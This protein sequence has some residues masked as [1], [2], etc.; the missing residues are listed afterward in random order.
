MPAKNSPSATPSKARTKIVTDD[1]GVSYTL[2]YGGGS[3]KHFDIDP[4]I[5][6]TR[7][8]WAQVQKLERED[9]R[10]A[11]KAATAA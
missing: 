10:A 7:P 4:R 2:H 9:K 3:L 11:K 1:N 6:L 5:D 8:I